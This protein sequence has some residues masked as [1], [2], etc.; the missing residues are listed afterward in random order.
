MLLTVALAMVV[1]GPPG[2][3][4]PHGGA[5]RFP[6]PPA[7]AAI[8]PLASTSITGASSSPATV[9]FTLTDPD[10]A[11]VTG[12]G[13]VLWTTS[14]GNLGRAWNVGIS[15]SS[16]AFTN[17]AEI[18]LSAVAVQCSSVSGGSGGVCNASTLTLTASTQQIAN[19]FEQSGTASYAV[20]VRFSIEDAWKYK[21]HTATSCTLNV[22]YTITAN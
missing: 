14:K 18:P 15:S 20:N 12:A 11:Q 19:G 7:Q 3:V 1:S 8:E 6:L 4:G 13:S 21:G 5:S 10:A 22:T 2:F 9:N 16:I 17:C